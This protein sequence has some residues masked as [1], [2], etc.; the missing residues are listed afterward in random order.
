MSN[1][2]AHWITTAPEARLTSGPEKV[3]VRD[4]LAPGTRLLDEFE[5]LGV[6]GTGGFGIV[7]LARDH[8]LQRDIA[9][10]EYL[11]AVLSRRGEGA[12][13][14]MRASTAACAES[15]AKGLESFLGEARLLASF[16]HPAL[17]KVHRFWRDNGTAYMAM[18]YY[19]GQTLKDVRLQML[20]VP[21]EPWLTGL[22][23]P[24]LGALE[25]L[26]RQ[27]VF[28]RDIAPDN[29][30]IL[31]DGRPVLLDFGSARRAV[32]SG[33]QWFTAHLKPQFA[34]LEQ[35]AEDESLG[36]GPWTDLYSLGAT[37][38]FVIS[39]R[40]PVASV[41]RAVR[42]T[43][44]AL[45]TAPPASLPGLSPRFLGTIDWTLALSPHDRPQ[46]VAA[47]RR[48]LRGE[49]TPPPPSPRFAADAAAAAPVAPAAPA[50]PAEP[51]EP[52]A[53]SKGQAVT[54]A[55]ARPRPGLRPGAA[56]LLAFAGLATLAYGAFALSGGPP[57]VTSAA[58]PEVVD[59]PE[60]IEAKAAPAAA[61]IP[62][63]PP[64]LVPAFA[65]AAVLSPASEPDAK[66]PSE[67]L[68][69]TPAMRP[70][71]AVDAEREP[72]V[73]RA[74]KRS[75]QRSAQA[76]A[77]DER[78]VCSAGAGMLTRALCVLNPCRDPKE[79]SAQCVDRQRAE[80]ARLR[81]MASAG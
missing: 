12:A 2:D 38:Y 26:H 28:H 68:E 45:S 39:G 4:S 36:Q 54:P 59:V 48:A 5:I 71:A 33:S 22:V 17:I 55:P 30:L 63:L 61:Q 67:G 76:A 65:P 40:A 56:L 1:H 64:A 3:S 43:L 80:E 74:Q 32:A 13:V 8:L 35:Y 81:R 57:P 27:G 72:K 21:A 49:I 25:V 77:R 10:K 15:F 52:G 53:P 42:D 69:T 70:A 6:L 9:I 41:V 29:I 31:P 44:P 79:R 23:S 50:A 11:P 75:A 14:T 51:V 16:D 7:Y 37:L 20:A 24:L 18:P 58:L 19:P 73:K 60:A 46:D 62:A 34:P 66:R 78:S 47:V